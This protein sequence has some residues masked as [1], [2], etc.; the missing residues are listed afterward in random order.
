[1]RTK[2]VKILQKISSIDDL[3][4]EASKLSKPKDKGDLLEYFTYYLYL[5]IP[6][7]KNDLDNVWLHKDVPTKT[8]KKL[9]LPSKDKGV[10]LLI[11]K[12]GKYYAIQCK[13]RTD[14]NEVISWSE[15]STFFG[16]SFGMTNKIKG[17]Y[18]VTNTYNVCSEVENSDK[19]NSIA[20]DFFDDNILPSF[21]RN[22][23]KLINDKNAEIEYEKRIPYV[24]QEECINECEKYFKDNNKGYLEM[25]CGTGKTL[26]SYWVDKKLKPSRT[27][28]LV[29][30]LYLL[31]Q[32]FSD[33]VNQMYADKRQYN[34]LLIGSDLDV[35]EDIKY[36][37]NGLILK[38][39]PK[40]IKK[41]L[42]KYKD[43][44]LVVICTYQSSDKLIKAC[45]SEY[46][47]QLACFD[48][49]HKTVGKVDKKFSLLLQDTKTLKIEKR[50]FMTATPKVYKGT[51]N[52]EDDIISMDDEDYYGKNIYSYNTGNAIIDKKLVDYQVMTI[53]ALKSEIR[54][55]IKDNKLVEYKKEFEDEEAHYLATILILL[56]KFYDSTCNHLI[57]YHNTVKRA[58]KFAKFL[59]VINKLIYKKQK[60]YVNSLDGKVSMNNRKKVIREFVDSEKGILCSARV[61]N[62]GVNIPIV[63]S[64]C[65]VD[66]RFST[67]DIVQ[68]IGRS[69]RLC[70]EKKI[71]TI[72]VPVFLKN[73]NDEDIDS[74]AFGNIVKI[75]KSLKNSDEG[76]T[77]Y[78]KFR[79]E[80][81]KY[82]RKILVHKRFAEVEG[83]EKIDLKEWNKNIDA[84]I[85]EM[86][87][88]FE[89]ISEKFRDW[90]EINKRTPKHHSDD[91][92][93]KKLSKWYQHRRED[94]RNGTLSQEKIKK[95]EL[96]PLWKWEEEDLF[97]KYFDDTNKFI[98]KYDKIPSA[99]SENIHEQKLGRWCARQRKHKSENTL[100]KERIE[101]LETLKHWQWKKWERHDKDYNTVL[102]EL[103][104]YLDEND[105][106]P[107]RKTNKELAQWIYS[108]RNEK[109]EGKLSKEK[110]KDLEALDH[111]TWEREDLFDE[112]LSK[113][114]KYK[115]RYGRFPRI[116]GKD[117][118]KE[119]KILGCWI[120]TQ[121]KNKKE[122]NLSKERIEKLESL[123]D[124]LW[125]RLDDYNNNLSDLKEYIDENNSLP[126]LKTNK[127]L[128]EW[129]Y[130][131]RADK[132]KGRLSKEKIKQ[133][134]TLDHWKW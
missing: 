91:I 89:Y 1:M 50:L 26:V 7:L 56:Q 125:D 81:K 76:I 82:S 54:K 117:M 32:F 66:N 115:K 127:K 106:L 17:G 3:H 51:R 63:D 59:E 96:I 42:E 129:I 67:I 31:S 39:K 90:V 74:S 105:S 121:R 97:D 102:I 43:E 94:K 13:F 73:M 36:K 95:L 18:L 116:N 86:T 29:P 41:Y 21:F 78:F 4:T 103:K 46:T 23:H 62:E 55:A 118:T 11:K 12:N 132:K 57:T 124:W 134:E 71:A 33:W 37:S 107:T 58:K 30:S 133:L 83:S 88:S 53:T 16:L 104:E 111:W 126:T 75:L 6:V 10:D 25:A 60:I 72:F 19:V 9:K 113:I 87:D 28:I 65:F 100:S 8:R 45:D 93:E 79:S 24:H 48:E 34:F 69:L 35:E 114:K 49:S 99:M 14:R 110:I 101:L 68:C 61:L 131:R 20:G 123:K 64:I 84:K 80:G 70:E 98:E 15:L 52:D 128:T 85:W 112:I 109:K 120:S 38:T 22:M 122:G 119:E 5:L 77:E 27:L 108:R 130:K 92:V 2:I 40:K 47:F 44:N